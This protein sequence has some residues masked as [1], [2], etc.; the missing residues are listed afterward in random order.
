MS[1]N[2]EWTEQAWR[3]PPSIYRSAPFWSWN[4][5]LV[6]ERL[7][8]QIQ[9]MHAA[10][11]GGF[12][13]RPYGA[14]KDPAYQRAAGTLTMQRKIKEIFDPNGILNPGKLCF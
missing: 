5:R 10:G 11:M 12:F 3:D 9:A 6:P 7:C 8:R 13:S 2:A 14:W 1:T 4:D